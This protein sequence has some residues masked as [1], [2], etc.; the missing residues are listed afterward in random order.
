[1]DPNVRDHLK[2]TPKRRA[3]KRRW[4]AAHPEKVAAL[5]AHY[6]QANRDRILESKRAQYA[7]HREERKAKRRA[8]YEAN[9]QRLLQRTRRETYLFHHPDAIGW[10]DAEVRRR[11]RFELQHSPEWRA[12]ERRRTEHQLQALRRRGDRYLLDCE[13]RMRLNQAA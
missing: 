5:N 12:A 11:E 10:Y 8:R 3:A 9:Q 2:T 6:Y 13:R 1:M 7:A 4:K